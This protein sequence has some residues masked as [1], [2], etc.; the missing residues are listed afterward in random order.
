MSKLRIIFSIDVEIWCCGWNNL[1]QVFPKWYQR[2][3]FGQTARGDFGLPYQLRVFRDYGLKCVF[4]VEPLFATRFGIGP[5]AD[6]VGMLNEAG[7]E[8]Q[9]HLHPE[10]STDSLVPLLPNTGR[11]RPNLYQFTFDEQKTLIEAARSLL[12]RAGARGLNAFRAGGFGF[13]RETLRALA[14]LDIHFDSSFNPCHYRNQDPSLSVTP[15]SGVTT[16]DGVVEVPV[17]TFEDGF[18]RLRPMQLSACS[19]SELVSILWQAR[20]RELGCI[21][22]LT[23]NFELLNRMQEKP[24]HVVIDRFLRLCS[25]LDR[26]RAD[27]EV[28]GF[29]DGS[30][31]ASERQLPCLRCSAPTT[32]V[33]MIQQVYRRRYG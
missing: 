25:F 13:N 7:Q 3:V 5:L 16:I 4:F 22:I 10:W 26:N 2:Y 33:R 28:G 1:D 12:E 8:V 19:F 20:E 30:I 11:R 15:Q 21:T 14:A 29:R 23:H 24:D 31:P 27:F 17:S 6:I 32:A 9:I 18:G